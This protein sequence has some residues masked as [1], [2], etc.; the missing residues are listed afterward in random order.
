MF[1]KYIRNIVKEEINDI[2]LENT[3]KQLRSEHYWRDKAESEIKHREFLVNHKNQIIIGL[4][5][6]NE[7][8]KQENEKLEESIKKLG[9]TVSL[10]DNLLNEKNKEIDK[11]KDL[12]EQERNKNY[13]TLESEE[14]KQEIEKLKQENE[15]LK[16]YLKKSNDCVKSLE[17]ENE[18]LSSKDFTINDSHIVQ[19]EDANSKIETIGNMSEKLINKNQKL[20]EKLTKISNVISL[21]NTN[22]ITFMSMMSTINNIQYILKES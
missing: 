8:L 6:E 2:K 12:Y 1:K 20:E 11:L 18:E 5:E 4:D 22:D 3:L 17:Q 9:G 14:L 15:K 21:Y 19:L 10:K 13:K 16:I 7:D